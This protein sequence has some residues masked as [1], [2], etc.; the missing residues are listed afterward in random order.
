MVPNRKK[1]QI[2]DLS[3]K[4]SNQSF[5]IKESKLIKLLRRVKKYK[6]EYKDT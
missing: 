6:F 4:Q 2:R 3:N 1:K 5:L